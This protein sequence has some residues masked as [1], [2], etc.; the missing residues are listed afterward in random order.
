MLVDRALGKHPNLPDDVRRQLEKARDRLVAAR[1]QKSEE[2]QIRAMLEA[3][4]GVA[5]GPEP[6]GSTHSGYAERAERLRMA[7]D[8]AEQL[9]G[10]E[11]RRAVKA[12]RGKT[13]ALAAEAI[14]SLL[15]EGRGPEELGT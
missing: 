7:L 9:T 12:I 2:A 4:T 8:V 5:A 6:G 10:R 1:R 3:V 13:D 11:K 15:P 14:E